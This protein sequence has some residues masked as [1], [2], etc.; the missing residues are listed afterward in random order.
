MKD[1]RLRVLDHLKEGEDSVNNTWLALGGN[2]NKLIDVFKEL[3]E[4]LVKNR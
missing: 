2:K 1:L 4:Y 3:E